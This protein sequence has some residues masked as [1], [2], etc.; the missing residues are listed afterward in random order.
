[1]WFFL[2]WWCLGIIEVI[3]MVIVFFMIIKGF[4]N[5]YFFKSYSEVLRYVKYIIGEKKYYI[6]EK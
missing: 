4:L 6:I 5:L 2:V 1:M 3:I